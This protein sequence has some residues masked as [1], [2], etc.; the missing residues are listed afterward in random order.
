MAEGL[1]NVN[2][3]V[4]TGDEFEMGSSVWYQPY[5]YLP[6]TTWGI[7]IRYDSWLRIAARLY[8]NYQPLISKGIDSVKASF[9]FSYII[10]HY[11]ITLQKTHLV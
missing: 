10:M 11:F 7:H 4:I 2:T 9:C 6:R 8:R 3:E 5:H 1:D